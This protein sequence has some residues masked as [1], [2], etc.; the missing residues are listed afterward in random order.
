MIISI[1]GPPGSGKSTAAQLI[2]KR[3]GYKRYY[4]GGLRREAARKRGM[5]I[6]E[7][8]K[9][10]ETDPSTDLEVDEYQERLG[11]EEDDF[12]IEGRTSF[13]CI[14]HSF[15]VYIDVRP[16]VGARR[17]LDDPSKGEQRNQQSPS[18][19]RE[20]ME[21]VKSIMASDKKRYQQYYGT[22][23]YDHGHY[24]YVIDSSGLT[25]GQVADR[26][27]EAAKRHENI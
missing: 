24:D 12:V 7:Y 13:R 26:I 14:P 20:A 9:L 2:A 27:I 4:M 17:L 16:E 11:R 3:L 1:S 10:G 18:T 15:K 19:L 25:P 5:T 22:D 6:E 23:C 8:N 21:N